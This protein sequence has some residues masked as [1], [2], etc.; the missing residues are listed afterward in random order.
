MGTRMCVH[1]RNRM[2]FRAD[3]SMRVRAAAIDSALNE[4][5]RRQ[6][7]SVSA[8]KQK[9]EMVIAMRNANRGPD[10]GVCVA[11]KKKVK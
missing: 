8:A 11:E 5:R 3:R 9:A 4:I 7:H 1:T 2:L 10:N 6:E